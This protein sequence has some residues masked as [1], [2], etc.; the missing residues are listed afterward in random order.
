MMSLSN[1]IILPVAQLVKN[2]PHP[3]QEI[4][5]GRSSRSRK[6]PGAVERTGVSEAGWPWFS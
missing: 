4:Q 5:T 1:V 3:Y 2:P 6:L